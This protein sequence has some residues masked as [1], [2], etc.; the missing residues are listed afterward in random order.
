MFG[1]FAIKTK[2]GDDQVHTIL[3]RGLWITMVSC[4]EKVDSIESDHLQG[5]GINHLRQCKRLIEIHELRRR[6]PSALLDG[7]RDSGYGS[8]SV[9]G[10]HE[11]PD[12]EGSSSDP[13][14]R[15]WKG[16]LHPDPTP[17]TD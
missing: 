11:G 16:G 5:A 17:Q 14:E 12:R 3:F 9:S 13:S 4:P 7:T 2:I 6:L 10:G 8:D 1:V 15:G